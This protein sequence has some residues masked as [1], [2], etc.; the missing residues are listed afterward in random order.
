MRIVVVVDPPVFK[1]S[2]VAWLEETMAEGA[3]S[4]VTLPKLDPLTRALGQAFEAAEPTEDGYLILARVG[5]GHASQTQWSE[6]GMQ[7]RVKRLEPTEDPAVEG[8]IAEGAEHFDRGDWEKAHRAYSVADSLLAWEHGPRR[9]EVLVCLAAIESAR[10]NAAQ[11]TALYDRALAIF[12]DHQA[13]LRQRIEL[14]RAADDRA[15]AAALGR[16][17][18]RRAEGGDERAELLSAIADDSLAACTEALRQALELRPRDSRLLERLQASLEAAG[19]WREAVDAKVSLSETIQS[20]RDRARAL[21]AAAGMCARRT[22]D[23]PRAVALYEAAIADDP[24][25]PGAF[26]AIESVLLK[27]E[28][29]GNVQAAYTR[30]LERLMERDEKTGAI[31]I[32][33]KLSRL[34]AERLG[35]SHGAILALDRLV[36]LDPHDVAARG[37]VAALL[38]ASGEL[39]LAARCLENAAVFAPTRP[40]T[41]RELQRICQRTGDLDRTY[42]ACAV[43]V[44][45]GEADLDEQEIYRRHAPETT[46]ARPPRS[47]PRPSPSSNPSSTT[48]SFRASSTPWRRPRSSF[49]S[50]SSWPRS[51]CR[52]CPRRSARI[53]RRPRSPQCGPSPGPLPSSACPSPTST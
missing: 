18:L 16:R 21:T 7:K 48:T 41:F 36:A 39:E 1:T 13:A 53:P 38:E 9:A 8:A 20:P 44:H 30:Q 19:R 51:A 50:S 12:P 45:L 46:C 17:L 14:A 11:A 27:N 25:A 34:S 6:L 32:L 47:T 40:E 22:N 5:T 4:V 26:E 35:D 49:A 42:S 15:T 33:D 52:S 23:V 31:A 37:R 10:G 3:A 29:F 2:P 28:D 24:S 43:L